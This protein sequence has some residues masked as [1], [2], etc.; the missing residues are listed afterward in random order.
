MSETH[1][2]LTGVFNR[3]ALLEATNELIAS[4][5]ENGT[6][7]S[8]VLLDLDQFKNFN[9]HFGLPFGDELIIKFASTLKANCRNGDLVGRYGGEEF[10]MVMPDT[11]AEEALLMLEDLLR[12][13]S[14]SKVTLD[15]SGNS[16]EHRYTFS[17]G[18]AAFPKDGKDLKELLTSA[19]EALF[20]SKVN[21][22]N[23]ITTAINLP[24]AC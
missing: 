6:P 11:M 5:T 10:L 9:D 7:L 14:K 8:I 22:R 19:D 12:Q 23:R 3:N 4:A 21:G 15:V 16:I 17:G 2:G 13:V 24:K 1:D 18:I 20:R